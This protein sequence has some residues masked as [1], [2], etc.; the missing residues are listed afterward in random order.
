MWSR[1]KNWVEKIHVLTESERLDR[2][3]AREREKMRVRYGH[4]REYESE[5]EWSERVYGLQEQ[6]RADTAR[7]IKWIAAWG[8]G[9]YFFFEVKSWME[10]LHGAG[11]C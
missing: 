1:W 6:A 9:I 5:D 3:Y 10:C 8:L 11:G 4:Q 2:K 7:L